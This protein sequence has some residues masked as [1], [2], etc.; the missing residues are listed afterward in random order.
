[1]V[2]SDGDMSVVG[3]LLMRLEFAYNAG[4]ANFLSPGLGNV[5]KNY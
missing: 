5:I 2:T 4:E 1:M 3:V